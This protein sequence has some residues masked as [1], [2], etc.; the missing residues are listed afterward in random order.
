[1]TQSLQLEPS[2]ARPPP[3]PHPDPSPN[4]AAE[5]AAVKAKRGWG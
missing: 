4:R 5:V 1:M 2:G 3:T